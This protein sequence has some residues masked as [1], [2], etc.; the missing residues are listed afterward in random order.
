MKYI[1]AVY[2][3]SLYINNYI[4]AAGQYRD[5]VAL[6]SLKLR[7]TCHFRPI[8]RTKS[9]ISLPPEPL[10]VYSMEGSVLHLRVVELEG[11]SSIN[12]NLPV[13]KRN[14]SRILW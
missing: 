9:G 14:C 11:V 13:M 7:P 2:F 1:T 8:C 5:L 12:V 6:N 10:L 3:M 4:G